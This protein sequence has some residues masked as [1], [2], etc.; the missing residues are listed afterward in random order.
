M[1]IMEK[2][3]RPETPK[4]V[5]YTKYFTK[6]DDVY[7]L[8]DVLSWADENNFDHKDVT[9][10]LKY[11]EYDYCEMDI[12]HEVKESEEDFKNKML[13]FEKAFDKYNK[14]IEIYKAWYKENKKEVD[15]EI[16]K[17]KEEA[18]RLAE[19]EKIEKRLEELKKEGK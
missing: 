2:P 8:E 14:D 18:K 4:R 11:I 10:S 5:K 9:I 15:K 1:E 17:R 19:I 6:A 12:Y 7:S 3:V 16:K 13:E